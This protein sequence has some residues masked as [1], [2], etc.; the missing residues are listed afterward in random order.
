[1]NRC[2]PGTHFVAFRSSP[3]SVS[4]QVHIYEVAS[5]AEPK[6]SACMWS[7]KLL[8]NQSAAF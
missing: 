4:M 1:M 3:V 6:L 5:A 7:E 8:A 2:S